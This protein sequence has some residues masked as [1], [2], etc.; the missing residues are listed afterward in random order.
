MW[1]KSSE[2]FFSKWALHVGKRLHSTQWSSAW[3]T[4]R[5]NSKQQHSGQSLK[6]NLE[7][8][9]KF[10]VLF[11]Y[12]LGVHKYMI[13]TIIHWLNLRP[14]NLLT[15]TIEICQKNINVYLPIT[16]LFLWNCCLAGKVLTIW[17]L[18]LQSCNCV[19]VKISC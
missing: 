6:D 16:Y 2:I 7:Q 4:K 5:Y 17:Y 9:P 8:N 11:V 12:R 3:S 10:S 14:H 18:E 13:F 19:S 15:R 1:L